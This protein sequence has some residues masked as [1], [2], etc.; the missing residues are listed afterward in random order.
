M[1]S[2]SVTDASAH[3]SKQCTLQIL[4]QLENIFSFPATDPSSFPSRHCE[5]FQQLIQHLPQGD[6]HCV[7]TQ[8]LYSGGKLS[9]TPQS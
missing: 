1:A 6:L 2:L 7:A 9:A 8:S 3:Q 4:S 5:E